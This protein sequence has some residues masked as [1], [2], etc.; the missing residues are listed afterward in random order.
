MLSFGETTLK[1]ST[2]WILIIGG[3]DIE[4]I[5]V[6]TVIAYMI[7]DKSLLNCEYDAIKGSNFFSFGRIIFLIGVAFVLLMAYAGL[8]GGAGGGG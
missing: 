6:A 3:I 8:T 1:H 4:E 2:K 7:K 5:F